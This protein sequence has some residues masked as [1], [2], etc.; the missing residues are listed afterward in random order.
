MATDLL[1]GA[2]GLTRVGRYLTVVSALPSV[3]F[4]AYIYL[5][6]KTGAWGGAVNWSGAVMQFNIGE[7]AILTIASFVVALALHP[8]QF[9]LTQLL[10][11]YWGI[12]P[13]FRQI[14]LLRIVYHRRRCQFFD[15][16]GTDTAYALGSL[17]PEE[18]PN[19]KNAS[20]DALDAM[21]INSE[22]QRLRAYYPDQLQDVRPTRLGNVLRRYEVS[23]GSTY[24]LA[25]IPSVPR[26]A[27]VA[28]PAELDYLQSQ[29]MQMD[30]AVRTSVLAMAATL[31]TVVVMY[32]HEAW[33]LVALIPYAVAYGAYRGA[34][35]VAHEYGTALAVLV[36]VDR[37]SL[38]ER[39]RLPLP[40]TLN[41]E[42]DLNK[43][44]MK[45]F[46]LQPVSWLNYAAPKPSA[47][48][49]STPTA[50]DPSSDASADN[51]SSD[52]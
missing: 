47:P 16:R 10:E 12:M 46:R 3:V 21:L 31:I 18:Q 6:I 11:G 2:G 37:F 36:E 49:D 51:G 1:S 4:T 41:E 50:A 23:A 35:T 29:R 14:A 27:V 25:A 43:K 13:G 17:R 42:Q 38:Y 33:M 22:C 8:L 30:L 45:A 32:R 40:N 9:S 34:V 7:A 15:D 39:L 48:E 24:G 28:Q 20:I 5:L 19:N 52:S 44:L 26:L